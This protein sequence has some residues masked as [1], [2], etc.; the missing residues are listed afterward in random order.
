VV[1]DAFGDSLIYV[2]NSG[3]EEVSKT[4]FK[5]CSHPEMLEGYR[6]RTAVLFESLRERRE[7]QSS[8]LRGLIGQSTSRIR[9][10]L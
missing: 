4:L 3:R 9:T 8:E 7:A 10:K 6:R 2:G 5:L 1:E